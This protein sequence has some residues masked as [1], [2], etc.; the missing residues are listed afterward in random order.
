MKGVIS[1][2]TCNFMI[3]D[4]HITRQI[5]VQGFLGING[6]GEFRDPDS[7]KLF[8]ANE[9]G[10]EGLYQLSPEGL[11]EILPCIFDRISGGLLGRET[12]IEAERQVG[13]F[14]Y[15]DFYPFNR[16][17]NELGEPRLL[18]VTNYC[19]LPHF[20]NVVL[21]V[22]GDGTESLWQI[23]HSSM[24]CLEKDFSEIKEIEQLHHNNWR[25][26]YLIK[27]MKTENGTKD[28][29]MSLHYQQT[30]FSEITNIVADSIT[31][32]GEGKLQG[33][34]GCWFSIKNNGNFRLLWHPQSQYERPFYQKTAYEIVDVH[35]LKEELK[36]NCCYDDA[37][38]LGVE[39]QMKERIKEAPK[40]VGTIKNAKD[41]LALAS[42]DENFTF[43]LL[44]PF[45]FDNITHIKTTCPFVSVG[46]PETDPNFHFTIDPIE[47]E[48]SASRQDKDYR[49]YY[50][51]SKNKVSFTPPKKKNGSWD[52]YDSMREEMLASKKE[53]DFELPF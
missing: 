26:V 7:Y 48:F 5:Y 23:F 19:D 11:K 33:S 47:C 43:N 44:T 10:K 1:T 29:L 32:I 17:K 34:N 8:V 15:T 24:E 38:D 20:S 41:C 18:N 16:F 22:H 12:Y 51:G 2:T 31:F 50:N 53:E 37:Y 45:V 21:F 28:K 35:I 46:D 6:I 3:N 9:N 13:N 39:D 4:K 49:L 52:I 36:N 14:M 27:G 30:D 25:R 40:M 42:I